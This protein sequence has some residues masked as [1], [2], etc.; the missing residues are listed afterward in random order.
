MGEADLDGDG[1]VNYEEFVTM[2]FKVNKIYSHI[3]CNIFF[4][5]P[6]DRTQKRSRM[7]VLMDLQM[8]K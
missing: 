8:Y 6:L 3:P 1:N 2:I 7:A 4:R 5:D